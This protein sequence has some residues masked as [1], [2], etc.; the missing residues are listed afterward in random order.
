MSLQHVAPQ[1]YQAVVDLNSHLSASVDPTTLALVKVRASMINGC[2]FCTD[3]HATHAVTHGEQLRRLVAVAA[4]QDAPFFTPRERAALALTDAL[5]RLAS[6]DDPVPDDLWDQVRELWSE[7]EVADL[8]LAI[9][10]INLWNR[11]AVST[12]LE[13]PDA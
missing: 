11:I 8:I 7:R 9:G 5:T 10:I 1:A 13:L 6:S 12:R 3:M 2:A 4:W